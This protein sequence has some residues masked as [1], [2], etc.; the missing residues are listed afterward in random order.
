MTKQPVIYG[1][2]LGSAA[3]RAKHPMGHATTE[4]GALTVARRTLGKPHYYER[5]TATL[6]TTMYGTTAWFIG[7]QLIQRRYRRG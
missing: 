4:R 3:D 7:P 6:A 2:G 5:W 1:P